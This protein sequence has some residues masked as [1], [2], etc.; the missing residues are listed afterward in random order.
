ML[1]VDDKVRFTPGEIESA[2]SLGIELASARTRA[3][4][5]DAVVRLVRVLE[6]E[7]PEL[8]EQIASAL[9]KE[10]GKRMPTKLRRVC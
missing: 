3:G 5:A 9:A 4:Y 10:T 6:V 2:R 1:T 7:R 8:L